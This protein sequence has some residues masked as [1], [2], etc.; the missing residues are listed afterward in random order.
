MTCKITIAAVRPVPSRVAVT[1]SWQQ[2]NIYLDRHWDPLY[3]LLME[4]PG[5]HIC[6]RTGLSPNI[7]VHIA[8]WFTNLHLHVIYLYLYIYINVK[9]LD[10][11]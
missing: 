11:F 4:R 6:N 1:P 9:C 7:I 3:E 5:L 10:L 8:L 2:Y